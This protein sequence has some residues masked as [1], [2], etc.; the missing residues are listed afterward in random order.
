[1]DDHVS[2]HCLT[3]C[4]LLLVYRAEWAGYATSATQGV[5]ADFAAD[6][7]PELAQAERID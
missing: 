6:S 3:L 2:N 5:V 7:A 4:L 1:M